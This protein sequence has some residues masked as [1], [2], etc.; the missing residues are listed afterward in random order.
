MS[1][2]LDHQSV[3]VVNRGPNSVEKLDRFAGLLHWYAALASGA[4]NAVVSAHIAATVKRRDALPRAADAPK[5]DAQRRFTKNRN[6]CRAPFQQNR[7]IT[8]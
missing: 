7:R 6:A 3:V 8:S 4:R 5:N 1:T 2:L